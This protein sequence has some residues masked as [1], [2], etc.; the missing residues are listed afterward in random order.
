M[1]ILQNDH[2]N[3]FGFANT[4]VSKLPFFLCVHVVLNLNVL[5]ALFLHNLF[6]GG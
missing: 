4:S 1:C 5:S 6:D 3:T 2:S